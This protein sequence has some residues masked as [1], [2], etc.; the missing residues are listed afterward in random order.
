MQ[1]LHGLVFFIAGGLFPTR[2]R[3]KRKTAGIRRPFLYY[4]SRFNAYCPYASYNRHITVF[5]PAAI[6]VSGRAFTWRHRA[7]SALIE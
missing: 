5:A 4:R 1:N 6:N 3:G 2:L 7:K